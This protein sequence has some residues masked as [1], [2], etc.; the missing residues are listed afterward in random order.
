MELKYKVAD[1]EKMIDVF[2]TLSEE[3]DVNKSA[4][5]MAQALQTLS[6]YPVDIVLV[7]NITEVNSTLIFFFH[8]GD[9]STVDITGNISFIINGKT[10]VA[11]IIKEYDDTSG[12]GSV[13]YRAEVDIS[14]L[15]G[16]DY[17]NVMA[18]YISNNTYYHSTDVLINFTLIPFNFFFI[19][20]NICFHGF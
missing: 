11:P 2:T 14:G 7:D 1:V 9:E 20:I 6:D 15:Y 18:S 10:F 19:A 5:L 3:R 13:S 12:E 17:L 4:K 16:G 8:A